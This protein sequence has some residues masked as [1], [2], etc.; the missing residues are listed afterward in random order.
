MLK[1]GDRVRVLYA[2]PRPSLVGKK[3]TVHYVCEPID[4]YDYRV[5]VDG[6]AVKVRGAEFNGEFYF[7]EGELE[8]L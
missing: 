6:T 1:V 4:K 5:K 2:G 7:Y 8:K 3:G